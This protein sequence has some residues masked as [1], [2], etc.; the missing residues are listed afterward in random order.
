MKDKA[1]YSGRLR[2]LL[3]IVDDPE[4]RT[5]RPLVRVVNDL[6]KFPHEARPFDCVV[7]FVLDVAHANSKSILVDVMPADNVSP[8]RFNVQQKSPDRVRYT[9]DFEI[10]EEERHFFGYGASHGLGLNE[11]ARD[12]NE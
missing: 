9:G 10:V 8:P 5:A 2:G 3:I 11:A 6:R 4:A 1:K 12:V 7:R